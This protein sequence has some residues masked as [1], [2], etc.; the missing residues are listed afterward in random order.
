[1]SILA[2]FLVRFW[3]FDDFGCGD[4]L[5]AGR[6]GYRRRFVELNF[7][8]HAAVKTPSQPGTGGGQS[9]CRGKNQHRGR[10]VCPELLVYRGAET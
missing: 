10:S 6:A 1:M 4:P 8:L 9:G 5:H 2:I 3:E 7:G